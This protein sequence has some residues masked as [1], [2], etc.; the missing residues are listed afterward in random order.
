MKKIIL[1]KTTLLLTLLLA[2]A[3]NL[4]AHNGVLVS[5][6]M[7]LKGALQSNGLMRDELR[8]K[9]LLPSTEPY[10]ALANFQHYG[11]GGGET[12]SSPG[13]F[14]VTGP[15]AIVDW[16]VVELRSDNSIST[17]IA[18]HAAL[19]QRDGDVV[20]VDGVSAVRFL[21]VAPGQYHVTVRHRNH[22]GVMTAGALNLTNIAT[23]VD[24]SN[25]AMPLYGT[26]PCENNGTT[27]MLWLGNANLDKKV[28]HQ[29]PYNDTFTLFSSVVSAPGNV[30]NNQNY[31]L[32]GY[33]TTDYNLDGYSIFNGPNND[34]SFTFI[35]AGISCGVVNCIFVEQ[36]P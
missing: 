34:R 10:S 29:G 8:A 15:N 30:N 21:T 20:S 1:H 9:G 19:L 12:I 4:S 26:T 7:Y 36:I 5:P 35:Q 22:L 3:F 14:S 13:V 32:E 25:P 2:T 31:M 23:L 33:L 18:T 28:I 27:R 24:F 6:K 11:D 17:P 16:V